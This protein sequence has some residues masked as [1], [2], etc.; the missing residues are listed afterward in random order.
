MNGSSSRSSMGWGARL[1]LAFVFILAGAAGSV[2]TLGHYHSAARLLGIASPAPPASPA[3]G[4]LVSS[5]RTIA[6]P[7]PGASSESA[8]ITALEQRLSQVESATQKAQGSAGRADALVVAFAARRAID[9]GV[10]L[11][12]LETLLTQR[13]GA[14]HAA[15]VATIITASRRP[16]RLNE[17]VDQYQGLGSDLRR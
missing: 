2:W 15:A 16:V 12:Y 13:F 14:Q 1:L 6:T 7:A 10:A 9:R 5:S 4:P 17:L 8:R 11:G 3:P